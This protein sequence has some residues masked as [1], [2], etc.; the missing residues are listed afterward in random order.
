MARIRVVRK[1]I[2]DHFTVTAQRASVFEAGHEGVCAR[3]TQTPPEFGPAMGVVAA[4]LVEHAQQITA[5]A[6]T[7]TR[8]R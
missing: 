2:E 7:F 6:F 1:H 5:Q 4:E 3:R 8:L